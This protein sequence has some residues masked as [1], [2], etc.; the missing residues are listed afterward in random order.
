MWRWTLMKNLE[1]CGNVA[2]ELERLAA[3]H[4]RYREGGI[5]VHVPEGLTDGGRPLEELVLDHLPTSADDP[6][7][8]LRAGALHR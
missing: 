7:R 4:R 5:H 2:E 1:S 6:G 3:L 8:A